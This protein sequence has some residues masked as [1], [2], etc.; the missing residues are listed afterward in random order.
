MQFQNDREKWEW[1]SRAPFRDMHHQEMRRLAVL[2][3]AASGDDRRFAALAHTIARDWIAYQTDTARVGGEDLGPPV[4]ALARGVDDCDAKARTFCALCLA[5]GISA[6][7][8]PRWLGDELS[9]VYAAVK[10][11]GRWHTVETTLA[12]ARIGDELPTGVAPADL[13]HTPGKTVPKEDNGKWL[14]A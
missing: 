9:H 12:R 10:L 8:R 13:G 11:D 4:S 1:L 6:E 3:R 5:A 7:M 14:L 2:L